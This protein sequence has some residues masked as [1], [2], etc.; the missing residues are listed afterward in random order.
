[1][2]PS[3]GSFAPCLRLALSPKVSQPFSGGLRQM[4]FLVTEEAG[5]PVHAVSR[6]GNAAV[7]KAGQVCC[8]LAFFFA[9]KLWQKSVSSSIAVFLQGGMPT[10]L[11]GLPRQ[12]LPDCPGYTVA[13][14][15]TRSRARLVAPI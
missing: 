1:M 14:M 4:C 12:L 6:T 5:V 11:C 8:L 7:R 13:F 15:G 10:A 9:R 2:T 3:R